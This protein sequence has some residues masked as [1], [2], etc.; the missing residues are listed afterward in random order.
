MSRRL[1]DDYKLYINNGAGVYN[2]L[3]G[4]QNLSLARNT[5]LIDQSAKGDGAY[6]VKVAGKTEVTITVGGVG[7][8]PD[9]NGW[10]RVHSRA[11]GRLNETYQ[12]RRTP[13]GAGDVVF[14]GL[15][16]TSGGSRDLNSNESESLSYTLTTA[17]AP[18]VDLLVPA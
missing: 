11:T 13:F 8:L 5:N 15:M 9:A 1:G 7:D 18:T 3:A 17:Q 2:A 14:E 12:I 4:E 10:E 16:S 6:A